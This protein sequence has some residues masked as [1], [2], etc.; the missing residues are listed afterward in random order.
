MRVNKCIISII[1]GLL[2][3]TTVLMSEIKILDFKNIK[4]DR[5][6]VGDGR[7]FDGVYLICIDGYKVMMRHKN[8]TPP[9]QLFGADGKPLTCKLK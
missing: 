8:T 7:I 1:L 6:W 3:S 4:R 9:I 5:N 2:F